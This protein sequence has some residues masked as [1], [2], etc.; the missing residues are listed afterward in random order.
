M[1]RVLIMFFDG[2]TNASV[3]LYCSSKILNQKIDY[4]SLKFWVVFLSCIVFLMI[5]YALTDS[6]LRVFVYC[7]LLSL[8]V[9][10]LLSLCCL[11][12]LCLSYA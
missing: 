5:G 2:F 12:L 11:L 7:I 8:C 10:L 1:S 4:K 6:F 9:M 3:H